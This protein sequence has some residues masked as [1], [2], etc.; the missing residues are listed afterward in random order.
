[1]AEGITTWAKV[2]LRFE[3][4]HRWGDAFE[5]VEFLKHPHRHE[6]HVEVQ[7]EQFHDDR[8]VEYIFLKRRLEDWFENYVPDDRDLGE[9]SCEMVAQ[10]VIEVLRHW[11]GEDRSYRVEVTE[12]GENGALV[13]A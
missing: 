1:M 3:A 6:F 7:V 11:Y 5:E 8:D 10:D 2:K 13:E 12:D 9:H 4:L